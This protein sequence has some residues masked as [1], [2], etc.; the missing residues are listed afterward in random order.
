MVILVD[1]PYTLPK[2]NSSHVKSYRTPKGNDRLPTTIF[3]GR[4]VK[5]RGGYIAWLLVGRNPFL[6]ECLK[7][8][9][10]FG[11]ECCPCCGRIIQRVGRHNE[12]SEWTNG[13]REI[14][15]QLIWQTS[16]NAVQFSLRTAF[17]CGNCF[18]EQSP[19]TLSTQEQI[20]VLMF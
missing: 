13:R 7:C 5:L 8:T 2:F 16:Q 11:K 4:A 15:E 19:N 14:L 18:R 6:K 1:F 12:F 9:L 17:V 3:Q 10:S 20:V